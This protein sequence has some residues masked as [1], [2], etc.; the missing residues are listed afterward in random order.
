VKQHG[1]LKQIFNLTAAELAE[2]GLAEHT[3]E[4][5]AQLFDYKG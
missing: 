1:S 4:L 5:L 2:A 3:P